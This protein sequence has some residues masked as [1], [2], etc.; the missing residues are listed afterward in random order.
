MQAAH[1]HS[2]RTSSWALD[3][4]SASY[5]PCTLDLLL[6]SAAAA[7]A[8]AAAAYLWLCLQVDKLTADAVELKAGYDKL[9]VDSSE[10]KAQVRCIG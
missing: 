4:S 1:M 7:A 9:S 3:A 6:T 2:P 5:S 10:Q 8:A